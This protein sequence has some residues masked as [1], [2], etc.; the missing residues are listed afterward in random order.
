MNT[1]SS[2]RGQAGMALAVVLIIVLVLAVASAA[3]L[4]VT[5]SDLRLTHREVE[6]TRAFYVAQAGIEKAVAELKV[7]YSKGK[8]HTTAELEKIGP[9]SYDGFT[10]DTF[11]VAPAGFASIGKLEHGTYKGLSGVTRRIKITAAVTSERL[12]GPTVRVSEEVEA[13]FIPIFQFAIFY[14]DDLEIL[15]G[16]KMTV[17]GPVHC[18][19]DIYVGTDASLSFDSKVTSVGGL[20]HRRKDGSAVSAGPVQVKDGDGVYREMRNPDGTWLD[21]EHKNWAA[22]SQ[23]RWDGNVA[24]AVHNVSTL[25]LPL[26]SPEWPRA[27]IERGDS[28]DTPELEEAKYYYQADLRIIDGQAYN[29]TGVPVDL[30]YPDPSDP[31]K[32]LNPVSTKTFYNHRE[33]TTVSVTE[34]DV[35]MLR[36]SG[37]APANGILYVSDD[38]SGFTKQDAV[39]LVNGEALP[40]G[41][42]TVVTDNPLYI[43][44]D[45]NAKDKQPASVMCDAINILSNS[46]QDARSKEGLDRRVASATTI[47]VAIIAGNTVTTEGRYNGGVENMPRFL[48]NWS[49]KTLTYR[50]SLVALWTSEIATGDW[51]YGSPYYTAPDRNWGYDSDLSDPTKAPPGMPSVY[52][53]EKVRW[54]YE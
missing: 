12:H 8:G 49:S 30:T 48:E 29:A 11:T 7:L 28:L 16:P 44:G 2:C 1:Y 41:G 34:V 4:G 17:S 24:S 38:R 42:F 14:N 22:E 35:A 26:V 10:F 19:S 54:Q 20:Y 3:F 43:Q 47:N 53:V 21:S 33:G 36:A 18:N 13:Q 40:E 32:K 46:W 9:P 23:K 52:S 5:N 37:K 39:R 31:S 45:Y 25:Q 51:I 27:I 50:G 6:A 15:P